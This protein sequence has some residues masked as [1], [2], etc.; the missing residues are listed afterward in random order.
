MVN[1]RGRVREAPLYCFGDF[2]DKGVNSKVNT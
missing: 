1:E 2:S